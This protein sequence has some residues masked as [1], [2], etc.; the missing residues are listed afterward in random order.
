MGTLET[1]RINCQGASYAGVLRL[2]PPM[3][4]LVRALFRHDAG[5]ADSVAVVS[6]CQG[7]AASERLEVQDP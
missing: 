6:T 7:P 1:R 2:L 3:F 4:R 5:S